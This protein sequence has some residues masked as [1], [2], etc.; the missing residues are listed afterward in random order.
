MVVWQGKLKVRPGTRGEYIEKIRVADLVP[1]FL[2]QKGNVFFHVGASILDED[3][4][5]VCDAWEDKESLK[6]HEASAEVARWFEIYDQ[7]VTD[8]ES[9]LYEL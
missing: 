5:I 8:S 2:R 6:A 9:D 7:Y 1:A 4:L 3:I